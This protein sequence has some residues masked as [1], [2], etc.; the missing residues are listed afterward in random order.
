MDRIGRRY[1]MHTTVWSENLKSSD[2]SG[3]PDVYERIIL[4]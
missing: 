1:E 4:K 2:G 3:N